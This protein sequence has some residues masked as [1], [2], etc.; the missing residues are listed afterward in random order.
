MFVFNINYK[1]TF[2]ISSKCDSISFTG[3]RLSAEE[4]KKIDSYICNLK[5]I[6]AIRDNG[7]KKLEALEEVFSAKINNINEQIKP[8][9]NDEDFLWA[10]QP[11]ESKNKFSRF[12]VDSA[13]IEGIGYSKEIHDKSW[14]KVYSSIRNKFLATNTEDIKFEDANRIHLREHQ[15]KLLQLK[16]LAAQ[17]SA[18]AD[19]HKTEINRINQEVFE[20]MMPSTSQNTEISLGFIYSTPKHKEVEDF[21]KLVVKR[22][23]ETEPELKKIR[24]KAFKNYFKEYKDIYSTM[25]LGQQKQRAANY[26]D[27]E[28]ISRLEGTTNADRPF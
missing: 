18:L 27:Q 9:L 26:A 7:A 3:R 5:A 20:E 17:K 4:L 16:E 2:S 23:V 13:Y 24:D 14:K 19:V 15:I 10:I 28:V 1:K 22:A 6:K 21:N 12:V 11:K 25:S 8:L